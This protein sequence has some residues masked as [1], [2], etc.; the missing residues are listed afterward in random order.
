M[1][2]NEYLS[3]DTSVAE[4]HQPPS[5]SQLDQITRG[6]MVK[7]TDPDV[8][9][10]YWVVVERCFGDGTFAGRIDPHC[11]LGPTLRHGGIVTFHED[12]IF[13]IWPLKVNATFDAL[14]FRVLSSILSVGGRIKMIQ[15]LSV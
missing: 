9:C 12:N 15:R 1:P 14:W 3:M 10:W 11:V 5:R 7:V 2:L 13:F 8:G 4:E 6:S